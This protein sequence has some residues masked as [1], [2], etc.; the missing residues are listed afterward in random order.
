[1]LFGS[2]GPE[3][4]V[5]VAEEE[6]EDGDGEPVGD[7]AP[8]GHHPLQETGTPHHNARRQGQPLVVGDVVIGGGPHG[9]ADVHVQGGRDEDGRG[10]AEEEEQ[11]EVVHDVGVRLDHAP[12]PGLNILTSCKE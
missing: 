1:M 8:L 10:E 12:R 9:R 5:G 2:L 4:V 7:H 6:E 3:Q 11:G